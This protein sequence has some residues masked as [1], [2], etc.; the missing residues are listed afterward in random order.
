MSKSKRA[1]G[2]GLL[3]IGGVSLFVCLS[4]IFPIG[5][6]AFLVGGVFFAAGAWVLAGPDIR[7]SLKRLAKT[8]SSFDP[9]RKP[10]EKKPSLQIDPLLP[11]RVL[12]LAKEKQGILS[13]SDVAISLSVPLDHAE[14]ALKIC[15]RSGNALVDYDVPK[16]YTLYRVPEFLTAEERK[17][18]E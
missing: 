17:R 13:V 7:A 12:K 11:V 2:Y 16:G 5:L 9:F 8:R 4:P 3:G 10:Q 6:E 15:E 1:L 14:E 18:I